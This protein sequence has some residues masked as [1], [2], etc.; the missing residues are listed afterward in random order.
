MVQ[1]AGNVSRIDD[2]VIPARDGY[3]LA[4]TLLRPPSLDNSAPCIV[5]GSA[6]AV[7]RG[8]YKPFA[9]A[10]VAR[11][12]P[13]LLFDYR[14]IGGSAPKPPMSLA[15]FPYRNRTWGTVDIPSV[16]DWA[17]RT[18]P[19]R[20][21]HWV[22]HSFGGFG[23]G[24]ADNNSLLRRTLNVATPFSYWGQMDGLEKYRIAALA[25]VGMP[26]VVRA[27][28][29]LPGRLLG[30]VDL[31]GPVALEWAQWLRAPTMF[32]DDATLPER[33]N[34]AKVTADML[35]LRITDDPWATDKGAAEWQRRF[36]GA[37]VR[38]ERI[39]PRDGA[40]DR[41]GHIAFFKTKFSETL[42]PRALDWIL[43]QNP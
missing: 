20:P 42:W 10:L 40:S 11:G 16:I 15:N 21:L 35:F 28:G 19:G 43:E 14:G 4:A 24:L 12:A 22:G 31:P 17:A 38:V 41:I 3:A 6:T 25:K 34:F 9:Q 27:K 32:F 7:P 23:F 30:G 39:T 29:K 26:L 8:Y 13:V 1:S 33:A 36:S 37:T 5:V 2:F 18:F